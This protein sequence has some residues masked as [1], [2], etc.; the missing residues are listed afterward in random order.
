MTKAIQKIHIYQRNLKETLE[1]L[2]L[3]TYIVTNNFPSHGKSKA[4]LKTWTR[5]LRVD[6]DNKQLNTGKSRKYIE[7]VGPS[8]ILLDTSFKID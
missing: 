3:L 7:L 5:D 6:L 8:I 4:K 2:L 1:I